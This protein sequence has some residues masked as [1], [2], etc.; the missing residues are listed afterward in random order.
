MP[1]E[2]RP[3]HPGH[4]LR[5]ILEEFE[6]SA[7]ALAKALS[8]PTNRVTAIL[9]G[10]RAITADTALR[11]ARYFDTS[12]EFWLNLQQNYDL[13]RAQ[14]HAGERIEREVRPRAA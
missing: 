10:T 2:T 13:R 7:N 3:I 11:F 4:V 1:F 5:E 8:V 6:M 9:N 12:P 14:V